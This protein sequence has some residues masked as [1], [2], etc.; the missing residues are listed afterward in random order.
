MGIPIPYAHAQS[1]KADEKVVGRIDDVSKSE[2]T[3]CRR[4]FAILHPIC[5]TFSPSKVNTPAD[6]S[7]DDYS[8]FSRPIF[9][10]FKV[11]LLPPSPV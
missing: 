7:F 11:F 2:S 1:E 4:T 8:E 9:I 3:L 10:L 5:H 6:C